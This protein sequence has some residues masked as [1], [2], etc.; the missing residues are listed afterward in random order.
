VLQENAAVNEMKAGVR[1]PQSS[2]AIFSE[3]R[4]NSVV[5]KGA[6]QLG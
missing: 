5:G 4:R 3:L 1:V 6:V 2:D